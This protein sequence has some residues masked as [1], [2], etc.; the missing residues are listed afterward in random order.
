MLADIIL[1]SASHLDSRIL[2]LLISISHRAV[3]V[4]NL[5]EY[6][7]VIFLSPI[8]EGHDER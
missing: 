8:V 2:L 6:Y 7:Y 1:I 4:E 3:V 5:V